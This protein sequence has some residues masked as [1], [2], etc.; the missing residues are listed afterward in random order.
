MPVSAKVF[1]AAS[2]AAF[3][4]NEALDVAE[5]FLEGGLEGARRGIQGLIAV[6]DGKPSPSE[7]EL[8]TAIL[9]AI[10]SPR[11]WKRLYEQK[12]DQIK[13]YV[14]NELVVINENRLHPKFRK[15]HDGSMS[16]AEA[17]EFRDL[18]ESDTRAA[19]ERFLALA[20]STKGC[21]EAAR[22]VLGKTGSS[23]EEDIVEVFTFLGDDLTRDLF[24]LHKMLSGSLT[25]LNRVD[26]LGK[27]YDA[28][29]E[30]FYAYE[31]A[32]S[33][34][35]KASNRLCESSKSD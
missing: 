5:R 20:E 15:L 24:S 32:S 10:A 29:A 9:S 30:S 25:E 8:V 2:S 17:N 33:F 3:I 7:D 27:L 31:V 34:V 23:G 11:P 22:S 16:S 14:V 26:C 12:A 13:R 4:K 19:I 6:V 18:V 1:D 35:S 21:F 28:L